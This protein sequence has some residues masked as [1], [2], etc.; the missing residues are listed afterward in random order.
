MHQD[1]HILI[2]TLPRK[3]KIAR[4]RASITYI[5]VLPALL[6]NADEWRGSPMRGRETWFITPL[7]MDTA[8]INTLAATHTRAH[9][10]VSGVKGKE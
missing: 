7:E 1:K 3:T 9:Q 2:I 4:K 10:H 6:Q 5:I 8:K